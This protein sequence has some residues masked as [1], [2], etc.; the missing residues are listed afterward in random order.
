MKPKDTLNREILELYRKWYEDAMHPSM[1][2]VSQRIGISYGTMKNFSS[3][4]D[5][6][7]KNLHKINRFLESQGYKLKEHA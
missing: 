5:T 2:M 1:R 7:D 3:G 6:A 4:M